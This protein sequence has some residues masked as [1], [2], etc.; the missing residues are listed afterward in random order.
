MNLNE[1]MKRKGRKDEGNGREKAEKSGRGGAVGV[2]KKGSTEGYVEVERFFYPKITKR[3]VKCGLYV[4]HIN[5]TI[6]EVIET[7]TT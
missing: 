5:L 4:N 7:N 1:G 6:G 3:C 2:P